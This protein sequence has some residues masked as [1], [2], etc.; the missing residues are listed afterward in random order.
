MWWITVTTNGTQLDREKGSVGEIS[1]WCTTIYSYL[2]C[3]CGD[4]II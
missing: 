3:G 4:F 2:T 1:L